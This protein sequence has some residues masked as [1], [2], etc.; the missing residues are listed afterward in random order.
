MPF[1]KPLGDTFDGNLTIS[2][3]AQYSS[4]RIICNG[5]NWFITSSVGYG[6]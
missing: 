3:P 5:V 6:L 2:L 4:Y 1:I